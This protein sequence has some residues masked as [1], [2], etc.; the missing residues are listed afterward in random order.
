MPSPNNPYNE[1]EVL[2]DKNFIKDL[3]SGGGTKQLISLINSK[4]KERKKIVLHFLRSKAGFLECLP[5]LRGM[6]SKKNLD[7]SIISTSRNATVLQPAIKSQNF[8]NYKFKIFTC[9]IFQRSKIPCNFL[10]PLKKSLI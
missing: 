8:K 7:I 4:I 3:Y 9:Q 6:I 10:F 1:K 2:K 5:E